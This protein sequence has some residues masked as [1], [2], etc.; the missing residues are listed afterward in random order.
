M[1]LEGKKI[2]ISGG[3]LTPA[4]ATIEVLLERGSVIEFVGRKYTDDQVS[5]SKEKKEIEKYGISFNAFDAPKLNRFRQIDSFLLTP[6]LIKSTYQANK[7]LTKIKPDLMLSFGGYLALPLA[8]A[9]RMQK[10]PVV[11]HEQTL[12][13]GLAN[14][15]IGIFSNATAVSWPITQQKYPKTILTGNPI[16]QALCTKSSSQLESKKDRSKPPLIYI[17][18]GNQGASAINQQVFAALSDLVTVYRII[19]QTGDSRSAVDLTMAKKLRDQLPS[20]YRNNYVYQ[21]WFEANQVSQILDEADL[22]ISRAGAN[23]LSELIVKNKRSILI[24]LPL[25]VNAEQTTN[26][27]YAQGLGIGKLLDQDSISQLS[28]TIESELNIKIRPTKELDSLRQLHLN[29]AANLT[30]LIDQVL[31]KK[32]S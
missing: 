13:L 4:I 30:Q 9:A 26:A 28:A 10:I 7:L 22:V 19:H 18:G 8:I 17:T 24:P 25:A 6:K 12:T 20:E 1:M 5:Q 16:R 3:H 29:G 27:K 31:D 23:T 11:T 14:R 2:L 32:L 15:L 21:A